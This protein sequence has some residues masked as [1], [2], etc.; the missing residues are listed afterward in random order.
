MGYPRISSDTRELIVTELRL[1]VS[2][3]EIANQHDVSRDA[4]M[5][6]RRR[7]GIPAERP[8]YDDLIP[9]VVDAAHARLYI[10][11]MLRLLSQ[12]RTGKEIPE[13]WARRLDA[14]LERL[15]VGRLVVAYYRHDPTGQFW[16]LVP[17]DEMDKDIIRDPRIERDSSS[18]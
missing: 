4:V 17:R 6:I 7:L 8:R 16:H 11:K 12:R 3:L 2:V 10:P 18:L 9:W 1:G 15:D 5:M 14:W 13:V